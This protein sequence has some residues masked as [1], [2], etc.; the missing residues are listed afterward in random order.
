MSMRTPVYVML[1]SAILLTASLAAAARPHLV[2]DRSQ[3]PQMVGPFNDRT[4]PAESRFA[5]FSNPSTDL[6]RQPPGRAGRVHPD[7]A[8]VTPYFG[9]GFNG[10]Y[11]TQQDR[12]LRESLVQDDRK[13]RDLFGKSLVPNEVQMGVRIPF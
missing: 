9:A 11:P 8:A 12:M 4:E 2:S 10:G 6:L 5:P 13:Q 7:D 1:L 3:A